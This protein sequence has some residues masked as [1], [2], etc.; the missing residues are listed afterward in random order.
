MYDGVLSVDHCAVFDVASH[1]GATLD[2]VTVF[3]H[4]IMQVE[5][6]STLYLKGTTVVGGTLNTLGSPYDS[7]GVI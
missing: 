6:G 2:G 7:G 1:R 5:E 4:G 3:N